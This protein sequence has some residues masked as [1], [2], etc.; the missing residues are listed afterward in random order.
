MD[1]CCVLVFSIQVVEWMAYP[2][3]EV[4][5]LMYTCRHVHKHAR[6][7][8]HTHTHTRTHTHTHYSKYTQ[9]ITLDILLT[10]VSEKMLKQKKYLKITSRYL[11]TR[12]C[13]YYTWTKKG[14]SC[15]H[16]AHIWL[17]SNS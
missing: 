12:H 4:C 17:Q 6:T 16:K 10:Y 3:T 15:V 13:K 1:Q 14:A 2:S 11:N 9:K 7:H 8:A 5:T